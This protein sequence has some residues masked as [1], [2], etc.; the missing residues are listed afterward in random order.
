MKTTNVSV[1]DLGQV[2]VVFPDGSSIMID[3]YKQEKN[4]FRIRCLEHKFV[5]HMS[6]A[7]NIIEVEMRR[8]GK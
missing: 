2:V 3:Q 7:V 6:G 1:D 5:V 8:F 4:H